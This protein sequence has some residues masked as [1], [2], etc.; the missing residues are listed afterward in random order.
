MHNPM[1]LQNV[2]FV[3]SKH[4]VQNVQHPRISSTP[5][6]SYKIPRGAIDNFLRQK[7]SLVAVNARLQTRVLAPSI[8]IG[9]I[10]TS[11]F[12]PVKAWPNASMGLPSPC[13]QLIYPALAF[14]SVI[15]SFDQLT[16]PSWASD[17]LHALTEYS[18]HPAPLRNVI[19]VS[20]SHLTGTI[21]PQH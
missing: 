13:P 3:R 16:L 5:S 21:Q 1:D 15:F 9:L 10:I 12:V 17:K 20:S 6:L 11:S 7:S 2:S 19:I 4:Y 14:S 8:V 18:C